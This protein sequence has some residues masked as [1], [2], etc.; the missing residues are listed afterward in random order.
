[1]RSRW[2]AWLERT[3]V[4]RWILCG[5]VILFFYIKEY[6]GEKDLT[7][8]FS[9]VMLFFS[10]L[11][12]RKIWVQIIS[13]GVISF[14]VDPHF[15]DFS[16]QMVIF[17]WVWSFGMAAF[18]MTL[19]EKYINEK[20]NIVDLITS[21]AKTLDSRDNYTAFHSNNVARYSKGIA[22][23]LKLP[24]NVCENIYMGGLLHDI[25]KIGIP[26]G[27]LNKS[28][29][30]TSDEFENIKQH[31]MI[32]YQLV[33]HIKP[34]ERSGMLNMI[35]YHHERY[36]GQGYPVGLRGKEIPIEARIMA[37]ADAFDAMTSH[38]VYREAKRLEDTL[39]EIRNQKGSQFDP[40]VVDAFLKM[41][42]KN[43]VDR[44][45]S[46]RGGENSQELSLLRV[47]S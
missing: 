6:I 38:R 5:L 4:Y 22:E 30:L 47:G 36:D 18:I 29:R 24:K 43:D 7:L 12:F 31:P 9:I 23:E 37:V 15:P 40:D 13:S 42:T 2:S 25:G 33:K 32:G 41:I 16:I 45:L 34:F 21:L 46:Q 28:S 10:A 20:S 44:L 3:D 14:L 39:N 11:S 27:I 8:L 17:H 19:I 35:L 26:E 1:M